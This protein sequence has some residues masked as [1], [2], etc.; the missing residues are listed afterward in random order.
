MTRNAATNQEADDS[1]MLRASRGD[2][3]EL[4]GLFD[5]HHARLFGF[6]VRMTGNPAASDDLVQEVFLRI[7]KYRRTFRAGSHF[8]SWMYQIA[9]NARI[10]YAKKHPPGRSLEDVPPEE[11]GLV[12]RAAPE[13]LEEQLLL[14]RALE[15]LAEDKR[16]LVILARFQGLRHREI[17]EIVGCDTSVVR[18]RLFRALQDL[19]RAYLKLT[20]EKV[21]WNAGK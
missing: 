15:E 9:R 3:G 5:R 8:A 1:A 14:R 4:S 19:R 10:D 12:E 2:V 17:G 21:L 20:G 7:L 6:F 13:R 16:E 18:V 11:A